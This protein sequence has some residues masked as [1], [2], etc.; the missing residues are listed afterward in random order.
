M[1]YEAFTNQS[2]TMMYEGIRGALMTRSNVIIATRHF[3]SGRRLNGKNTRLRLRSKCSGA[4]C[5][6]K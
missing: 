4:E 1:N 2:L 3:G 5:C 6:S